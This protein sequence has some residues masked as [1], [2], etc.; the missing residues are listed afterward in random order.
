MVARALGSGPDARYALRIEG[1][2][3]RE[4]AA[5]GE[6]AKNVSAE[7]RDAHPE[8]PWR[9]IVE[10]RDIVI[11]DYHGID[12]E[13]IW[14]IATGNTPRSAGSG[15]SRSPEHVSLVIRPSPAPP[16]EPH[17]TVA[18]HLAIMR[19]FIWHSLVSISPQIRNR[20]V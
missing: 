19:R 17:R 20:N 4:E 8:M 2:A 5:P 18:S 13:N 1:D 3:V 15:R 9:R 6:A 14:R 10:L 11:H 16:T 7:V 12:V